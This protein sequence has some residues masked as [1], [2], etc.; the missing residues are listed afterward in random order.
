MS[1]R[2]HNPIFS[3]FTFD[4]EKFQRLLIEAVVD[5]TA[6]ARRLRYAP[7]QDAYDAAFADWERLMDA[8][9]LPDPMGA[10]AILNLH[11]PQILEEIGCVGCVHCGIA[12][13]CRP[14]ADLAEQEGSAR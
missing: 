14:F 6:E 5:P 7:F 12:W 9:G 3:A 11:Y 13:P 4:A 8:P 10:Y 2:E 1:D